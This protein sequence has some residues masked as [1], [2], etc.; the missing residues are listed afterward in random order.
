MAMWLCR[1]LQDRSIQ[2]RLFDRDRARAERLAEQLGNVTVIHGDATDRAMFDEEHLSLADVFIPLLENDETNIIAGVLAKMRGVPQVIT[3]V[4]QAKYLDV[5]FDIGVDYAFS[6]RLVAAEEID[7]VL[8]ES[9]LRHLGSLAEGAIEV[10]RVRVVD[11]SPIIGKPLKDLRLS[12]DWVIAAIQRKRTA[13]VPGADDVFQAN[14]TVL[15][16]G[17]HGAEKTLK[18]IFAVK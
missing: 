13:H 9:P 10:Y 12:P 17:K 4:E 14:D 2:L 3:V 16:V 18:N 7:S 11:G 8:D 6:T 1:A 15:V 5:T